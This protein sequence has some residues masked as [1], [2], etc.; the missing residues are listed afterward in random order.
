MNKLLCWLFGHKI[1]TVYRNSIG[2]VTYS[3]SYC[4]RCGVG[5]AKIKHAR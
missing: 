2:A 4:K 5:G 1:V 3:V